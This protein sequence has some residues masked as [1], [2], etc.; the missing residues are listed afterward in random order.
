M[1]EE[2]AGVVLVLRVD[3]TSE[4]L[5]EALALDHPDGKAALATA[6]MGSVETR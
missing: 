3:D 2:P 6:P 1:A 4:E 5:P